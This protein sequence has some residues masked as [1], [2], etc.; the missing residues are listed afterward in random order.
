MGSNWLYLDEKIEFYSLTSSKYK[1]V[2]RLNGINSDLETFLRNWLKRPISNKIL[3]IS[4]FLY[5]FFLN[6]ASFVD[7]SNKNLVADILGK[8]IFFAFFQGIE[9]GKNRNFSKAIT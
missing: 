5:K 4:N 2:T 1:F 9:P 8:L 6:K 3:Q 7:L